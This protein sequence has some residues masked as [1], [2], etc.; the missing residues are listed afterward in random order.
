[1]LGAER[2][3]QSSTLQVQHCEFASEGRLSSNCQE[4][5]PQVSR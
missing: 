5:H 3:D 2:E 1:M 4:F